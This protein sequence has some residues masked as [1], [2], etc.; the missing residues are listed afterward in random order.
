MI[1]FFR[2]GRIS[3]LFGS[4]APSLYQNVFNFYNQSKNIFMVSSPFLLKNE[5]LTS[6]DR[7]WR[8]LQGWLRF[9]KLIYNSNHFCKLRHRKKILEISEKFIPQERG[10][11]IFSHL[12][13]SDPHLG[14]LGLGQKSLHFNSHAYIKQWRI[15]ELG[16]LHAWCK[17]LVCD[18][19]YEQKVRVYFF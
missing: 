14:L 15:I 6:T 1:I 9:N 5:I 18:R 13:S 7:R 17:I 8:Y 16:W 3:I 12:F 4:N 10:I 11:R 19:V 2:W